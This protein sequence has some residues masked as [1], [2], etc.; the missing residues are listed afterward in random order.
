MHR[1]AFQD[2]VGHTE[3]ETYGAELLGRSDWL[4]ENER[5]ARLA[6]AIRPPVGLD[7]AGEQGRIATVPCSGSVAWRT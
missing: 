7:G 5:Q 4:I 6:K 3:D 2:G 1:V